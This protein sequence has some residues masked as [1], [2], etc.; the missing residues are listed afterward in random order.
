MGLEQICYSLDSYSHVRNN[1]ES[2]SSQLINQL[3]VISNSLVDVKSELEPKP[4]GGG[5][6]SNFT[7]NLRLLR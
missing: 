3:S 5:A 4:R 7:V 2:E 6:F 1:Q